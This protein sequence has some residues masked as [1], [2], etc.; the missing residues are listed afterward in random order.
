MINLSLLGKEYVITNKQD[1]I[2]LMTEVHG[3]ERTSETML[4]KGGEVSRTEVIL[5]DDGFEH[6]VYVGGIVITDDRTKYENAGEV[7]VLRKRTIVDKIFDTVGIEIE[8]AI[9]YLCGKN[10]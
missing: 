2:K 4:E 5:Y 6:L 1:F 3:W 10:Y 9:R 8:F 7:F